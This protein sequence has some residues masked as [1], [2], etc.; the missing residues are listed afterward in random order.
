[1]EWPQN[2]EGGAGM[3]KEWTA[4]QAVAGQQHSTLQHFVA[5]SPLVSFCS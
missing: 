3:V 5:A 2:V 1:M 4:G